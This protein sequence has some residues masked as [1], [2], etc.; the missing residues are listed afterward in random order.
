MHPPGRSAQ[1]PLAGDFFDH[2]SASH[3][4]SEK[5]IQFLSADRL[6]FRKSLRRLPSAAIVA[7]AAF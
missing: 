2:P 7:Y 6:L 5:L 1:T 4:Q 3:G